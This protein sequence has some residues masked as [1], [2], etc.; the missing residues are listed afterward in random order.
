MVVIDQQDGEDGWLATQHN[1]SS[2]DPRHAGST[3][4]GDV[5]H[6][7]SMS[8]VTEAAAGLQV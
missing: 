6:L 2:S 1:E 4:H 5:E 3:T 7:P 8:E